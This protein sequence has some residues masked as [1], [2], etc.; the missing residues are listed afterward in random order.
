MNPRLG[1][2]VIALSGR[3]TRVQIRALFEAG[4]LNDYN[5]LLNGYHYVEVTEC[6]DSCQWFI[7]VPNR[8]RL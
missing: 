6:G 3:W 1:E 5:G 4:W 7:I 8:P 2:V